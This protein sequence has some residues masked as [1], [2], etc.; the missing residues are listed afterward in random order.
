MSLQYKIYSPI[1][2]LFLV[3]SEKGLQSINW[4]RQPV[5]MIKNLNES[6]PIMKV[7]RETCRQLREYFNGQRVSFDL[8]LDLEGTPFQKQVWQALAQIPF[9]R[10]VSYRDIAKKIRNPKAVRA[11]GTAN[12][13]NPVCIVVPCH[14]V[15]RADGTIGGY[16]GGLPIKRKLLQLEG[17]KGF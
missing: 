11:V 8:P 10:T 6:K 1:G 14:R 12:G 17:L 15:I 2:P 13:S 7:L 5:P 16:G 3:A 9:G 4:D